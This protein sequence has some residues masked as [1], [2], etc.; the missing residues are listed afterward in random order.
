MEPL[1]RNF[2]KFTSNN[3]WISGDEGWHGEAMEDFTHYTYH[4]SGGYLIVCICKVVT[5]TA[6]LPTVKVDSS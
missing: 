2:T 3:G 5:D 1:I 6:D 4:R